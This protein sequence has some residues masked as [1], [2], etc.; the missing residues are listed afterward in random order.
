MSEFNFGDRVRISKYNLPFRIGYKPRFTLEVFEIVA[1][2]S[3]KPTT[4]TIKDAQDEI[5]RG[6]SY[7]KELIKV[8]QKWKRLQ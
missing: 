3:R 1:F 2:T 6:K 4:Y 8:I 7:Q 5:I